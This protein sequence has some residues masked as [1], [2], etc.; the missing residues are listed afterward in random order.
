MSDRSGSWN[1]YEWDG[2]PSRALHPMDA[3]F[4]RPLWSLGATTYGF[5]A[6]GR[7][8]CCITKRGVDSLAWLDPRSGELVNIQSPY[9]QIE[10]LRC[11]GNSAAFIGAAPDLAPAVVMLE[12][13]TGRFESITA[14][15]SG[16]L[17]SAEFSLPTVMEWASAGGRRSHGFYYTPRNSTFAAPK[18][19][20][21]PLLVL[22]HSG[23]TSSASTALRYPLQFW[24]NRG[25]AVLDVNYGGSTGF[26]V[27]Y[28]RR[29]NG[30]W[31]VIDV[32]DCCSGALDVAARGQVDPQRLAVKGG[33]AGGFTTLSCLT[34]RN[35]VFA[36]G[37]AYYALTD[38]ERLASAQPKFEL[39]Y[40]DTL[41]GPYPQRRDL[42]LSRSPIRNVQ[43]LRCPLILFH[44]LVDPVIP[45]AQS[46][47]MYDAVRSSGASSSAA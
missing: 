31:G 34:T 46:R 22:S 35:E 13:V 20:R 41:V 1:L 12:L 11:A 9:S 37:S 43:N 39:H 42:Y 33:S 7:I 40:L 38:L 5:S 47:S 6:G 36:A 4:G 16:E 25:F 23:P 45:P 24:T 15:H 10:F 18:S 32:E 30:Q 44:G 17:D 28:R 3:D 2:G 27:E 14:A 26:G 19:E 8:L 21:P 29:L